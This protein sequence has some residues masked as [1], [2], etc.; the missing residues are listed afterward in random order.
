MYEII[1]IVNNFL[2]ERK[3]DKF[4]NIFYYCVLLAMPGMIE[5]LDS[6]QLNYKSAGAVLFYSVVLH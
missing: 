1:I 3:I 6:Y 2:I 5:R 4:I